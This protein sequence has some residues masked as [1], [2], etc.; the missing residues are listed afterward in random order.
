MAA[1]CCAATRYN[2]ARGHLLRFDVAGGFIGA[3][4]FRWDITPAIYEHNGT[5]SAIVKDNFYPVGSYSPV[6]GFCGEG[7]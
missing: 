4:D 6:L 5:W 3:Y 1:A 2:Y 7:V